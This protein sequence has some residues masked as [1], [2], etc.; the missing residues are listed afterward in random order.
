MLHF[1]AFKHSL[2]VYGKSTKRLSHFYIYFSCSFQDRNPLQI[3]HDAFR[4][5]TWAGFLVWCRIHWISVSSN[6][7]S[8]VFSHL[9]PFSQNQIQTIL[10]RLKYELSERTWFSVLSLCQ[11]CDQIHLTLFLLLSLLFF[12]NQ[13]NI[14]LLLMLLFKIKM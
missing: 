10:N 13:F 4:A 3:P 11:W 14:V 1:I 2:L 6:I 9:S 12:L 8:S 5:C 7:F